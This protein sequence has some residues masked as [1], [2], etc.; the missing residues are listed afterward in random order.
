MPK[1]KENKVSFL[2]A[3][4]PVGS[5]LLLIIAGLFLFPLWF[6]IQPF[7][8]EFIFLIASVVACVQLKYLGFSWD[9]ISKSIVAKISTA[10]PTLLI[11][12]AIGLIIGSWIA[13]GTIPM[14]VYYGISLI[15]PDFIYVIA[16]I[17]PV[18]FSTV[19][20]LDEVC[21]QNTLGTYRR[22]S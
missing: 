18:I 8:L 21:D 12:L 22:L 2:T 7:R 16:F 10:M 17:V 3:L 14:L 15:D 1:F 19:R 4:V 11:L 6:E 20:T 5:L 13:C 9:E